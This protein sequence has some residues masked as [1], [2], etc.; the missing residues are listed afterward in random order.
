[1]YFKKEEAEKYAGLVDT[2][3]TFEELSEWMEQENVTFES[4]EEDTDD[5]F[6]TR[7]YP[8]NGGILRTMKNRNEKYSYFSV[9]GTEKLYKCT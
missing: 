9:D 7:L 3:L 2:V 6:I 5:K 8:T 1:M 4:V